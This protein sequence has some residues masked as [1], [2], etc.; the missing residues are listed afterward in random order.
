MPSTALQYFLNSR[1]DIV[2]YELLEIS[3]PGFTQTYRRVRNNADGVSVTLEGGGAPV[4]F[5][6]Y[7][8]L[9]QELNDSADLDAGLRISFGDLG[10]VLPKELD[11]VTSADLMQIKPTVIYRVYRS[12][13]LSA[14][15]IG[16]IR[17]EANNFSFTGEGA[18]FEAVAPYVNRTRTGESYNLTRFK[19]LRAFLK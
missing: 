13:D 18:T 4:L 8:M 7:P 3:H 9:I 12:D 19:T 14:P 6:W 2:A 5:E 16:P 10:E 15:M 11:A 17:L 1:S